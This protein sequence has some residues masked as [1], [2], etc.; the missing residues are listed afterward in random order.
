MRRGCPMVVLKLPVDVV[1]TFGGGVMVDDEY[2]DDLRVFQ[3]AMDLRVPVLMPPKVDP[4][5][6]QADDVWE[7]ED[8]MDSV[9]SH[10]GPRERNIPMDDLANMPTRRNWCCAAA[11]PARFDR[12][13]QEPTVDVSSLP[14]PLQRRL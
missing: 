12:L 1:R 10:V 14:L 3:L 6:D 8:R 5:K 7:H 2:D 4:P 9:R 13:W 11:S